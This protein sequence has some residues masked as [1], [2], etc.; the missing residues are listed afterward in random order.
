[1]F[2]T[3]GY[4][5]GTRNIAAHR[6]IPDVA[7]DASNLTGLALVEWI[8]GSGEVSESVG[9]SAAAPM[10]AGL[11]A[12]ADQ[13]AGHRL[14]FLNPA[15][16]AIGRGRHYQAAFHDVVSGN[17]SVLFPPYPSLNGPP[18]ITYSGYRAVTGWD[19]MTGWGSANAAVL[20]PLLARG[21]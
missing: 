9:T 15:I 2:A 14:G 1:V 7:A 4:Q 10:W 19:A 16:Y 6:G 20:V 12:L 17:N 8:G 3:P 13:Y 11:A 21:A 18:Y 5:K